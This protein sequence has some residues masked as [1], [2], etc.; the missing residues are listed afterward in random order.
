MSNLEQLRAIVI[1]PEFESVCRKLTEDEA[2]QLEA[3]ILS[4][5][6][7]TSPL[8]V[9]DNILLDGHN[10]RQVIFKHPDLEFTIREMT[11]ASRYDA[12]VWICKN[13]LVVPS[14]ST[15][16]ATTKSLGTVYPNTTK[17][18]P[19]PWDVRSRQ[20]GWR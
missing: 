18:Q 6:A 10:R 8:I 4:D 17:K 12:A 1:D 15:P 2:N 11:F 16:S 3:N 7:V 9:W 14:V 5:G 19:H 13:Q 20:I